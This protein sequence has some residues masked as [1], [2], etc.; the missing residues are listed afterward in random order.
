MLPALRKQIAFTKYEATIGGRFPGATYS[1]VVN[2]IQCIT[3]GMAVMAH[4][5][6]GS[7]THVSG[8]C[9]EDEET[10]HGDW[11]QQLALL[12]KS[13]DFNSHRTTSLL[14]H[15]SAAISN[16]TALPP[17][18]TPLDPFPIAK[19]LEK[20]DQE[21]LDIKNIT[22]PAFR[23]FASMEV[24]SSIVNQNLKSLTRYVLPQF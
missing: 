17:F 11:L 6:T 3:F 7:H 15:L 16:Q 5:G 8:I 4:L 20:L 2:E 1:A 23:A 13:T 21:M 10:S 9:R 24:M 18:T 12:T 22:D 14:C 19:S